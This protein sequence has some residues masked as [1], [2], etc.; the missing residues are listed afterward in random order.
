ME[1]AC[2]LLHCH[3]IDSKHLTAA[4][5][6]LKLV[7][8]GR[9]GSPG[10][11]APPR[12]KICPPKGD[13]ETFG[14]Q[15]ERSATPR[16]V[17]LPWRPPCAGDVKPLTFTAPQT[18][19]QKAARHLSHASHLCSCSTLHGLVTLFQLSPFLLSL[20]EKR[21]SGSKQAPIIAVRL[22]GERSRDGR[23]ISDARGAWQ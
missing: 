19:S 15:L 16:T 21:R 7:Q 2:T 3:Q 9:L 5:R 13:D 14:A 4:S 23:R 10:C 20:P 18:A 1:C 11:H 8:L 22:R 12:M 6:L 17:L